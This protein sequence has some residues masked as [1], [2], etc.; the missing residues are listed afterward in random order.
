LHLWSS[1]HKS[2]G[3]YDTGVGPFVHGVNAPSALSCGSVRRHIAS[4]TMVIPLIFY[5]NP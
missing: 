1:F 4:L 3:R 2:I 5:V